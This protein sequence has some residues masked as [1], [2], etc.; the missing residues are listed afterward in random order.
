MLS[1]RQQRTALAKKL[2]EERERLGFSQADFAEIGG[3]GRV[4][5]YMYER[6]ERSPNSDYLLRIAAVGARV[7]HILGCE[8][9][10]PRAE[11][12]IAAR[13]VPGVLHVIEQLAGQLQASGLSPANAERLAAARARI[14]TMAGDTK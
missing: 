8:G 1:I 14:A 6:A 11:R 7:D 10:A 4:S 2:R 13:D 3:V 9:E 12:A 5:Q